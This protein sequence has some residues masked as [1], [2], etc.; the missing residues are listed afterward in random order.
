MGPNK[1]HNVLLRQL[2]PD[3][4][5]RLNLHKVHLPAYREIESA[6]GEIRNVVFIEDGIASIATS[7]SDGQQAEVGLAGSES[8][9]GAS[10]FLGTRRSLNRVY[11]QNEGSGYTSPAAVALQEFKR[12]DEFQR[13]VLRYTQAQM[14]QSMQTAGCNARHHVEQRLARWLLLCNDRL[15]DKPLLVSQ[16]AIAAVLGV[17]R[18]SVSLEA[19]KFRDQGL[20]RYARGRVEVLHRAGLERKACECYRIV[21]DHLQNYA[22]SEEGFGV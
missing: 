17:Q 21:R 3:A 2:S 8:V 19:I 20:I 11:M 10:A 7:F 1:F 4:V 16:G 12:H 22:D 13:L 9:L 6:G 18:S 5:T 14:I 15:A